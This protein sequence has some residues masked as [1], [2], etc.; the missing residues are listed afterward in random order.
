M[1]TRKNKIQ[2]PNVTLVAVSSVQIDETIHALQYSMEKIDFGQVLFITHEKPKNLPDTI[3]WKQCARLR[4]VDEYSRFMVFDLDKYIATEFALHIHFDG[5]IIRPY[6]W[7]NAFLDYDYVGAPWPEKLHY[8]RKGTEVRVGNGG[9]SIRSKKLLQAR[10]ALPLFL[11]IGNGRYKDSKGN[12]LSEAEV[13][14]LYI[15]ESI[16]TKR[17]GAFSE[18]GICTYFR[19]DLEAQGIKF[20]PV[21]LASEF[22]R[23]MDC[24][25]SSPTPF[26]FHKNFNLRPKSFL[27]KHFLIKDLAKDIIRPVA[28]PILHKLRSALKNH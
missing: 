25:D 9:C 24:F 7:Q 16:D 8:S 18:D 13:P 21:A 27:L 11:P 1:F 3:V 23:E 17:D 26:G 5:F 10:A 6:K 2:L 28:R 15:R 22:S 4:N 20:A 19:D 14:A 12:D